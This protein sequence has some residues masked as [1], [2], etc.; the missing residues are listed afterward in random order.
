[1]PRFGDA[2]PLASDHV[3]AGFDCSRE[4]LNLWRSRYAR[5]AAAAG[6][7]R[8]YVVADSEQHRVVGYY[9]LTAAGLEPSPSGPLHLMIVLKD[10]AAS[11]GAADADPRLPE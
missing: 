7:A 2:E 11:M 4:L 10:I 9:A 5:Q 1:M 8:T 3:L 6:S